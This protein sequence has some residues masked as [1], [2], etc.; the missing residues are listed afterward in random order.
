LSEDSSIKGKLSNYLGSVGGAEDGN[1][2]QAGSM[3]RS[4]IVDSIDAEVKRVS[5]FFR[6]ILKYKQQF[7]PS[8]VEF[9]GLR[10]YVVT[11]DASRID[12]KNSAGKPDLYVKQYEEEK[13]MDTFVL[14]DGSKTMQLGT[15]EKLKS[16]YA[17]LVASTIAYASTD[18]GLDVG[19]ALYGDEEVIMNPDGGNAQY[20]QVLHEITKQENYGGRFDLEDSL[21]DVIAKI[22]DD[23]VVFIISDFLEVD[24]EWKSTVKVASE[25]F[26]HV[27]CIMVRD[28]RDYKLPE[29]GNVRL[30]DPYD[31]RKTVVNTGK[32]K[33]KYEELAEKQEEEVQQTIEE[34][35]A[36]FMKMDT[37]EDFAS[38]FAT[39]FDEEGEKW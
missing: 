36:S 12:W 17:S 5:E 32:A 6:F 15:A 23:T 30:K 11:D 27:M 28:L 8:G 35:G 1:L 33:K 22:K 24:G 19:F 25:K 34:A 39:Y 31:E 13:N 4:D 20:R 7:Q 26:R 18:A 21:N 10:Q 14:L 37:R 9:S 3:S 2:D 16:E 29:S 38:K